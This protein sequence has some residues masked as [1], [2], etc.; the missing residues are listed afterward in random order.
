MAELKTPFGL[1]VGLIPDPAP[2]S[3]KEAKQDK[4]PAKEAESA[5]RTGRQKADK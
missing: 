1:V 4:A 5:K 2:V 3:D